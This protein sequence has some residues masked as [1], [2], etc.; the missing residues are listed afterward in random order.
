MILNALQAPEL[1]FSAV[2]FN[3]DEDQRV[4]RRRR[5]FLNGPIPAS[6][7]F[8]FRPLHTTI[9]L[10]IEK[11]LDVLEIQTQGRRTVGEDGSTV[12]RRPLAVNTFLEASAL[13]SLA[14]YQQ[15]LNTAF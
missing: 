10:Q 8:Y 9:Y 11:S 14:S 12:L 15:T 1:I 3:F 5:H 7:R 6:F 2:Q 4:L 13:Y